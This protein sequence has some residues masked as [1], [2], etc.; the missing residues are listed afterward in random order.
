MSVT[1]NHYL[2]AIENLFSLNDEYSIESQMN[3]LKSRKKLADRYYKL[4]CITE[5]LYNEL[6]ELKILTPSLNR[7][8]AQNLNVGFLAHAD[9]EVKN[10]HWGATA[11][12]S[13]TEIKTLQK[14]GA[15]YFDLIQKVK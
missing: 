5:K 10:H 3:A 11:D 6:K 4:A 1:Y 12:A 8:I 14:L 13:I 2:D 9:D 15:K 7:D